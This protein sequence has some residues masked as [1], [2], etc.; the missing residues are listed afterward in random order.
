MNDI[1]GK[2]QVV[3]SSANSNQSLDFFAWIFIFGLVFLLR[4]ISLA[5]ARTCLAILL[6][7]ESAALS[8]FFVSLLP[9]LVHLA[10]GKTRGEGK[11]E[12]CAKRGVA[13]ILLVPPLLLFFAG[14][15]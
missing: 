6:M 8:S 1:I 9:P 2:N 10:T 7:V 13:S 14:S 4:A 12:K 3:R 5:I 11:E 15:S